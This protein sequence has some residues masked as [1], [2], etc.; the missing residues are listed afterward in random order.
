MAVKKENKNKLKKKTK[1][2]KRKALW[3]IVF[4][5]VAF[6]VLIVLAVGIKTTEVSALREQFVINDDGT[7]AKTVVSKERQTVPLVSVVVNKIMGKGPEEK[8]ADDAF[9][10]WEVFE[11]DQQGYLF[12]YPS[13]F[14]LS[15][16]SS[17]A[18]LTLKE[19]KILVQMGNGRVEIKVQRTNKDPVM[20]QVLERARQMV[21]GSFKYVTPENFNTAD[22]RQ[23]FL[24]TE[25]TAKKVV[26]Q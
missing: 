18:E 15:S 10:K 14:S 23:R 1:L 22:I 8:I 13:G 4:G 26:V 3:P 25:K 9:A 2:D 21:Q 24:S 16:S 17:S 20:G 11:D 6:V 12:L 5:L 7:I 19:Q